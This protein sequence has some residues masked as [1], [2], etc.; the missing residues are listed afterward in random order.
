MPELPEEIWKNRVENEINS[1][2]HLNVVEE[3]SLAHNENSIEFILNIETY[4]FTMKNDPEGLDLVPQ[5]NHRILLKLNRTFPYPG[6]VDFSWHSNIFHP[7]IHPVNLLGGEKGTGYICLNVLKKWSRLSDLTTTVKALKMLIKNPNPDDPLNY[8]L[9]LEA[10]KFFK[11][12]SMKELRAQ[13]N[14][15]EI[16]ND[17]KDD[18]DIIILD[19]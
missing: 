6:G 18:D 8:P 15:E 11:A 12:N 10:A 4:G 2:K 14:I 1:L 7:N 19:D 16:N 9:C 3:N 17:K 5:K 13:Y